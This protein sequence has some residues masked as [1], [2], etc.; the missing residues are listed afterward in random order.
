MSY[1]SLS[2]IRVLAI[3]VMVSVAGLASGAARAE[4][5]IVVDLQKALLESKAGQDLQKQIE[6]LGADFQAEVASQE[7]TLRKTEQE[8]AKMQE[9][10]DE[11][12]IQKKADFEKSLINAK[13]NVQK[14][15]RDLEKA[16][17]DAQNKLRTDAIKIIADI[18]TKAKADLVLNRQAVIV[19]AEARDKTADVIKQLDAKITKVDIKIPAATP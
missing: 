1:R 15:R 10:P 6:K 2:F 3:A 7:D 5:I 14:R 11:T 19:G 13:Q 8:L 17:I 4:G 16:S 18:A 9:K 12:F